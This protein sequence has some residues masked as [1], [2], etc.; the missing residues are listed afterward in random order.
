M[1]S[2]Q[3]TLRD[4]PRQVDQALRTKARQSAKSLNTVA[5]EALTAG[6]GLAE[7]PVIHH[8]LDHLPGTWVEDAAF[9]EAIRAQDAIDP[10]IWK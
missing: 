9:D 4:V 8:D 7:K 1:K 6:A 10:D 2:I 5:L 3:Y